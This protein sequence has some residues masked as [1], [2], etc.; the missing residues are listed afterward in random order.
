MTTRAQ[1]GGCEQAYTLVE[2]LVVCSIIGILASMLLPA[3]TK[4]IHNGKRTRCAGS[5]RQVA[6]IMSAYAHDHFDHYPQSVPR[7][8]GGVQEE[9]REVPVGEGILALHPGVFRVMADDFKTPQILVCPVTKFWVS[10][11]KDIAVTNLSF[12]VNLYAEAGE[13]AVPLLMDSNV[14][15]YWR[16]LKEFPRYATNIEAKFTFERHQAIGN[17][18]FGDC[19]VESLKK[20]KLSRP[21]LGPV[22]RF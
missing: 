4:T 11:V 14:S 6:L 9:N 17:V 19:H 13:P 7:A 18:A 2:V 12:A 21:N 8:S 16:E 15:M 5:Q 3:V 10:R 20:V 1:R 22:R